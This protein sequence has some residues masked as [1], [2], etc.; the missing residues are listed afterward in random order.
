MNPARTLPEYTE[1]PVQIED[2]TL[3]SLSLRY[4]LSLGITAAIPPGE[5]KFWTRAIN[6]VQGGME[7]SDTEKDELMKYLPGMNPLFTA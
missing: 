6:I 7:I 4:T 3:S 2:E 1:Q 5:Y